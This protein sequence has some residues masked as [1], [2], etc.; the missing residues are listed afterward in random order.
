MGLL[1]SDLVNEGPAVG[2]AK[3]DVAGVVVDLTSED[4]A[5]PKLDAATGLKLK[6]EGLP[7]DTLAVAVEVLDLLSD[8]KAA[9]KS[10]ILDQKRE[11]CRCACT[12]VQSI[13]LVRIHINLYVQN[14]IGM[15]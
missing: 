8:N 6:P 13:K 12:T 4:V 7:T 3:V 9:L 5:K 2:E 11:C 1:R 14:G 10:D 15:L